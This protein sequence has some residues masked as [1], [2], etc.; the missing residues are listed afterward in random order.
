M[1]H[2]TKNYYKL[3]KSIIGYSLINYKIIISI[4]ISINTIICNKWKAA[5]V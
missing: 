4:S 3:V 1:F 2:D 5:V